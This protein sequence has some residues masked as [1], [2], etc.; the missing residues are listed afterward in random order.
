MNEPSKERIERAAR[1]I[2]RAGICGP[3][4]HLDEQE[5]T[6]WRRF[7]LESEATLTADDSLLAAENELLRKLLGGPVGALELFAPKSQLLTK[8]RAER[9]GE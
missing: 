9:E 4:E 8:I 1:A 3:K 6:H 2:C 5:A 7:V